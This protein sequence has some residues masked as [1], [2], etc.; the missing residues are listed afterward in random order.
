MIGTIPKI[1]LHDIA[2]EQPKQQ[3]SMRVNLIPLPRCL[4]VLTDASR[5]LKVVMLKQPT[6]PVLA[7][8]QS[9]IDLA[10]LL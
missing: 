6:E 4:A 3:Q 2:K 7:S 5:G 1:A 9:R 8:N 10:R